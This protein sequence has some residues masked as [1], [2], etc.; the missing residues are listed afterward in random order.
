MSW[1]G[2]SGHGRDL[3]ADELHYM[4]GGAHE[5]MMTPSSGDYLDD[6]E[7]GYH[8]MITP[9]TD[10]LSTPGLMTP[11]GELDVEMKSLMRLDSRP[12]TED[13]ETPATSLEEYP[14]HPLNPSRLYS[15]LARRALVSTSA[16]LDL[17]IQVKF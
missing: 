2:W 1:S 11:G 8:G 12:L 5:G 9:G 7:S 14:L 4:R 10:I 3:M 6:A 16:E 15:K 17:S 13:M